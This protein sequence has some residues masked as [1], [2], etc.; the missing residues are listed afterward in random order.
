MG[1]IS[2]EDLAKRIIELTGSSSKI[3]YVPYNKAYEEGFE[4]MPRRVP[5]LTKLEKIIGYKPNTSLDEIIKKVIEYLKAFGDTK[6]ERPVISKYDPSPLK[7]I[8]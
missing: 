7:R 5:D 8:I 2:I 4:D 6:E 1:E 3:R